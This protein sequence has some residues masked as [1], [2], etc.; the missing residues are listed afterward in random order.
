MDLLEEDLVDA[1]DVREGMV[2]GHVAI[3]A[4]PD[5]DRLPGHADCATARSPGGRREPPASSRRSW[6][7]RPGRDARRRRSAP[8]ATR[9]AAASARASASAKIATA[10]SPGKPGVVR[11]AGRDIG[12]PRPRPRSGRPSGRHRRTTWSR[13]PASIASAS[14]SASVR[15]G[16][17]EPPVEDLDAV[18]PRSDADRIGLGRDVDPQ[19]GAAPLAQELDPQGRPGGVDERTGRTTTAMSALPCRRVAE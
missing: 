2:A 8:S 4:P 17:V 10:G 3:V 15:A 12:L 16:G 19:L 14:R 5:V 1:E 18:L 7:G 6:P 11:V 13:P 9:S